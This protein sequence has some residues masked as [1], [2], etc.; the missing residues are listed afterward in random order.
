MGESE[1]DIPEIENSLQRVGQRISSPGTTTLSNTASAPRSTGSAPE[2]ILG[3]VGFFPL[4]RS[5]SSALFNKVKF[6]DSSKPSL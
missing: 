6:S 5:S 2:N 3:L 4:P 1:A